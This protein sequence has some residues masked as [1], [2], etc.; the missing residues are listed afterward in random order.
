MPNPRLLIVE[1]DRD[2]LQMMELALRK[3]GYEVEACASGAE[4]EK[5]VVAAAPSAVICEAAADGLA[6]CR[7]VREKLPHLPF[8][9]VGV[10]RATAAGALEAGA[11]EFLRKPILLKELVQRL[12]A[13]LDRAGLTRENCGQGFSGSMRDLGLVDAL[14]ALLEGEKS[15]VVSCEGYGR[16][17][18][19]W[20]RE[21][22]LI[23]AELGSLEGAPALWRLVTWD[24]GAFHVEVQKVEREPRISGGTD[25]ALAEALRR[26]QEL[27]RAAE[28]LAATAIIAVDYA[29]LAEQLGELPDE[30][31]GVLRSFDGKRTLREATDLSPLDDL[32]TIEV[33]R[34]LLSAGIVRVVEARAERKPTL[35]KW[36]SAPPPPAR[37][38]GRLELVHFPPVRGVRRER[39]RRE[40]EQA[41]ARV[42]EGQPVRLSGLVE[43]PPWQAD[44][45]DALGAARR[46][47][48]AVSEAARSFAPD[49]PVARL[50]ADPAAEVHD[51]HALLAALSA[52]APPGEA[53][54]ESAPPEAVATPPIAPVAPDTP[55]PPP[56]A[57]PA[58][59]R[60]RAAG[61]WGALGAALAVAL[62]VAWAL[63]GQ[64]ATQKDAPWLEPARGESPAAPAVATASAAPSSG[65]PL[66]ASGDAHDK[67]LRQGDALLR[68][69]R[70]RAAIA[71]FQHAV[72]QKP[73]SLPALLALGDAYLEADL[74]RSAIQPLE[75]AARID[76]R[77]ARAQ[78]LLGTAYQ[79]LGRNAPAVGSYRR[80]LE[81]APK[82]EFTRDVRQILANLSR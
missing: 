82:G 44:G 27:D 62:G 50:A 67:A 37:T 30:V 64:P 34:R 58:P 55:P 60:A 17:A 29:Q 19:L 3:A 20:V 39:L 16:A 59:S 35:H 38:N 40:A 12:R 28:E 51:A 4:V 7:A 73:Q 78:L 70:Y 54:S 61:R 15:A 23:D 22:Q 57:S 31:N 66:S 71:Q 47:S 80:Y 76:P 5:R 26:A 45:S 18:R 11:D 56:A 1:P 25:A 21:G 14:H 32:G 75:T 6:V 8:M 43:L 13:L 9:I 36:L 49:A 68:R 10:D 46:I 77:S 2:S 74:P 72:A 53:P 48:P 41:R 79:S 52:S 42:E 69:G 24:S 65:A 81:L 33:V 63:R